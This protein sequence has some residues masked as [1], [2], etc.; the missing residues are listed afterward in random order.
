VTGE[1]HR[2]FIPCPKGLEAALR[3]ELIEL[4]QSA[5]RTAQGGVETEATLSDTYRI[6]LRSRLA[7]RVL[8]LIAKAPYASEEDVYRLALAQPWGDWFDVGATLRVDVSAHKSPLKSLEFAT[9][10]IKDAVCDQFRAATGQRPDVDTRT[11]DVRIFAYLSESEC[12]LYIDTSG[13][14]LFKRGWRGQ[15]G[16]APLRENLAAGILRIAGWRPG[17]PLMDPM[18]GS[19]TFLVEAAQTC[20]GLPPGAQRAF[21]FEKLRNFDRNLWEEAKGAKSLPEPPELELAGSDVSGDSVSQTRANLASAGISAALV[22][23]ISLKQIDA[24]HVRPHAAKGIMVVNPPYGERI[25]VRG[26][27]SAELFFAEF[28]DTLKQRFAGWHCFVLTSDLAFQKKIRLA[29][30]ARTPLYNGAIECRLYRFDLVAG[31]ARRPPKA[32]AS[33]SG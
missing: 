29:P 30:S 17:M 15:T 26:A 28:G 33:N 16:E 5:V 24:R 2:L 23:K 6:N 31:S 12:S 4:G 14:A 22:E 32:A 20:L 1:S 9:L 10:R 11:P 21:G 3:E 27:A 8:W 13:E 7:S 19:G 25:G 18:C